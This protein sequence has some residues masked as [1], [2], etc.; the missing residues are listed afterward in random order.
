[1]S[2]ISEARISRLAHLVVDGLRE[3]N[4]AEFPNEP[5]A[6][7]D[8]KKVLAQ[9]FS[10]EVAIDETVRRKIQSLSRPVPPG[11]REWEVLYRKYR[12]EELKKR[13]DR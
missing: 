3:A 11:S 12:E 8:I 2:H 5:A 6:L 9:Y 4:I 1:M 13:R 10:R 7:R